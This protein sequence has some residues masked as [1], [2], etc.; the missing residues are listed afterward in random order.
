MIINFDLIFFTVLSYTTPSSIHSF[1]TIYLLT[2]IIMYLHILMWLWRGRA[3]VSK[4]SH[5][6]L[7]NFDFTFVT[8]RVN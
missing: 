2:T 4:P 5:I 6:L 8:V 1:I 7:A 3:R